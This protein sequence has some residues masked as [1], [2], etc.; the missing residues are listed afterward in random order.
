MHICYPSYLYD[1]NK[2]SLKGLPDLFSLSGDKPRQA[3]KEQ[4]KAV[5]RGSR[6]IIYSA[7]DNAFICL[8]F[9]HKITKKSLK[10]I[11]NFKDF[12]PYILWEE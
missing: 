4:V 11:R 2:C 6:S 9:A 12:F 7:G 3:C 8:L 10:S 1:V 5:L